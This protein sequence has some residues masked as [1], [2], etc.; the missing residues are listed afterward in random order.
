MSWKDNIFFFF[1]G[2]GGG[3]G[4]GAASN[5]QYFTWALYIF[6]KITNYGYKNNEK[7]SQFHD[8]RQYHYVSRKFVAK[9]LLKDVDDDTDRV[10]L[11]QVRKRYIEH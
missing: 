11:E 4:G 7:A 8:P 10:E 6:A 9:F 3:G 5:L 2:G 1:L